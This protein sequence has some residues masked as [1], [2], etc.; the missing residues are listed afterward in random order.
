[1]TASKKA[2]PWP[3]NRPDSTRPAAAATA[4]AVLVLPDDGADGQA[5][6]QK[7]AG[8]GMISPRFGFSRM[9]GKFGSS[10]PSSWRI[11]S[12]ARPPDQ[13]EESDDHVLR[14]F[15]GDAGQGAEGIEVDWY[16][17]G[18]DQEGIDEGGMAAFVFEYPADVVALAA[19]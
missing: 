8:S 15:D 3:R 2:W 11:P 6:I 14:A 13:P 16:F 17:A 1:M 7:S 10:W 4:P 18:S 9:S 5:F 12:R 19:T